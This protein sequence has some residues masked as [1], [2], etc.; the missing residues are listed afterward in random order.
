MNKLEKVIVLKYHHRLTY[1]RI[2]S[3][4]FPNR[5]GGFFKLFV[6][7]YILSCLIS[8]ILSC[9]VFIYQ[10]DVDFNETLRTC[11]HIIAISQVLGMF[12]FYGINVNQIK[13][14]HPKLQGFVDETGEYVRIILCTVRFIEKSNFFYLCLMKLMTRVSL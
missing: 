9:C 11:F 1:R 12:Y 14:I 8:F 3:I 2:F 5:I 13:D 6:P 10:N 4:Q 7:F